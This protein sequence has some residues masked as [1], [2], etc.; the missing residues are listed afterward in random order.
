M[1]RRSFFSALCAAVAVPLL[2]RPARPPL[3]PAYIVEYPHTVDGHNRVKA[4]KAALRSREQN[5]LMLDKG[6]R[7]NVKEMWEFHVPVVIDV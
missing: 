6:L 7:L 5:V 3:P 4:L 2:P 1:N